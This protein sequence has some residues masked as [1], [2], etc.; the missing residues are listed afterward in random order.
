VGSVIETVL[1][2]IHPDEL[3][4]TSMHDHLLADSSRL[5]RPGTQPAP[6]GDRVTMELLGYLRW[7][8][9]ALAD[10][11]RLDDPE[12]AVAE[13]SAAASFG[14][15][16]V[17]DAT[18]WG[19]GPNHAALP[20]I[21]RR[22]GVTIVCAYGTYLPRTLPAQ[23]AALGEDALETDFFQALTDRVPGTDFRAG[24]LGIMG[25][26]GTVTDE[27]R[28]RLRAGAR[29]AARAGAAMTVRLD[30]HARAGVAVL[31]LCASEGLP[32][33]R[34][35]FTNVDEY[36]DFRY[37]QELSAA[38]AVLEMC[39]GTEAGQKGRVENP[40][41][42]QRLDFFL[43]YLSDQPS[44]RLVLG[45]S[46][47]TKAQLRHYGGYGYEHLLARIVPELRAEGVDEARIQQMLV[48]EPC[49]LLDHSERRA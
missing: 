29:A 18:C 48:G 16:T 22:S 43:R 27:E 5:Q 8:Q 3:G 44:S 40:S 13:L 37:W 49:R 10:N 31:E 42:H 24:L 4:V 35:I 26:T 38:G 6:V 19:L 36:L 34:V 7:N 41:D 33:D 11:L 47:W 32:T 23:I 21:S 45:G 17:V 12:L 39:F 9:L 1:G 25:T 28:M 2:A 30:Q 15:R 20:E 46:N 14:Q